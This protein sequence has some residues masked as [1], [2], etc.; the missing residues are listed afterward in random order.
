MPK[1]TP[2]RVENRVFAVFRPS[3]FIR[4]LQR[5]LRKERI[6]L[7]C[8]TIKDILESKG[9]RRQTEL[10]GKKFKQTR[11]SKKMTPRVLK[12]IDR[13]ISKENP[14]T[15]TSMAIQHDVNQSTICRAVHGKLNVRTKKKRK[16]HILAAKDRKSR[17]KNCRRLYKY[18]LAG[19]KCK[20]VVTLDESYVRLK[21]NGNVTNFCYIKKGEDIPDDWVK[22]VRSNFEQKMMIVGAM[23]YYGTFPLIRIR[24]KTLKSR[25]Y[26]IRVLRPLVYQYIL[27]LFGN[28]SSKV[29]VHFDKAPIH[30]SDFTQAY[31]DLMTHKF[32]IKFIAKEHIPTKGGDCSPLDFFGFGTL[33]QAIETEKVRTLDQLWKKCQTAWSRITPETC[34]LVYESWKVRC[35][36]IVERMGSHCEQVKSLHSHKVP[37]KIAN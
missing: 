16:V 37:L 13:K 22:E 10:A 32:G 8:S 35:R 11:S 27:P 5:L 14:P 7:S 29:F 9:K 6:I 18:H 3:M 34:G 26:V 12:Q 1:I 17:L 28:N 4:H 36:K 25:E 20:Y 21:V 24:Q 19:D 31:M 30:V 15:Q 33:K 2:R 23:S